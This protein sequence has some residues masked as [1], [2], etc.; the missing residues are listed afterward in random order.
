MKTERDELAKAAMPALI[1]LLTDQPGTYKWG[2]LAVGC[3]GLADA[4]L[5]EAANGKEE[6]VPSVPPEVIE[7]IRK[8][9]EDYKAAGIT[10]EPGALALR[11][12][13][14]DLE[15]LKDTDLPEGEPPLCQR[16]LEAVA[17]RLEATEN[18][19]VSAASFIRDWVHELRQKAE[20]ND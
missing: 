9:A 14:Y 12:L 18:H 19:H 17:N 13:A 1:N 5:A 6:P 10:G 20:G 16:T 4:M 3:Y 7:F 15:S 11:G 2:K 8:R